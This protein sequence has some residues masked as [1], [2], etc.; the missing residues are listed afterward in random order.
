MSAIETTIT[1]Q[2]M[3]CGHCVAAV[4]EALAA[5][6]GVVGVDLDLGS[7]RTIVTSTGALD[8]ALVVAAVADA[9][10]QILPSP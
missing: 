8:H 10:Y 7:G 3:T 1:V 5:L 4:R 6:D 9:G 2:G